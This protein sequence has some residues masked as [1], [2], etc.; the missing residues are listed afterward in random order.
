MF[1]SL[2]FCPCVYLY[3]YL[4][5]WLSLAGKVFPFHTAFALSKSPFLTVFVHTTTGKQWRTL[6]SHNND[7]SLASQP[8]SEASWPVDA[9]GQSFSY[10]RVLQLGA[11][12]GSKSNTNRH[13]LFLAGIELYGKVTD[14]VRRGKARA[15]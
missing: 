2:P 1:V 9:E 14:R 11:N 10:F 5:L 7:T 15:R 4:C 3:T 12:S 6:R 13:A 8:L